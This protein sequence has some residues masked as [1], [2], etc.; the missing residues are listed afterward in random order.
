MEC[1]KCHDKCCK[2]VILA[3]FTSSG[4]NQIYSLGDYTPPQVRTSILELLEH[5]FI[6]NVLSLGDNDAFILTRS[7]LELGGP[8]L[9]TKW[10]QI[11]QDK[12][13]EEQMRQLEERNDKA[14]VRSYGG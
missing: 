5:G 10:A 3:H 7:G 4:A 2:D 6:K 1:K 13:T 12:Q 14:F 8:E 11:T 9:T